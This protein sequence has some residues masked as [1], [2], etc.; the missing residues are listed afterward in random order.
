MTTTFLK[1]INF[2]VIARAL[3]RLVERDEGGIGGGGEEGGLHIV[4]SFC[5]DK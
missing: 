2:F 5:F 4:I 1:Y 3:T